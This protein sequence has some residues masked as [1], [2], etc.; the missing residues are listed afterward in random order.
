VKPEVTTPVQPSVIFSTG[1][2]LQHLTIISLLCTAEGAAL[3]HSQFAEPL[4]LC[5]VNIYYSCYCTFRRITNKLSVILS[6][7]NSARR[8]NHLR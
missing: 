7:E 5:Y 1:L 3:C 6:R 8:L 2:H 4:W